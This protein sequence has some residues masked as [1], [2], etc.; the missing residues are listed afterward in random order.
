MLNDTALWT[1]FKTRIRRYV[2]RNRRN[3]VIRKIAQYCRTYLDYYDNHDYD[4]AVNGERSVLEALRGTPIRQIFDVGANTGDWALAAAGVF[5]EASIH[6]F[7]IVAS[8]CDSLKQ[9]VASHPQIIVNRFG[10]SDQ[11]GTVHVRTYE[12]RSDLA[13]VFQYT[14]QRQESVTACPVMRGDDYLA[15]RGLSKIDLMKIDVEGGERNV[16][17]GFNGA[18]AA[19]AISIIQFEYGQVNIVA[20]VL[21]RDLW[22]TLEKH[23]YAVGKIYPTYVDFRPYSLADEDFRGPNF[24]AVLADREDLI[25][26]VRTH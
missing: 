8:T 18:L 12:G 9:R 17:E 20:G 3:G 25:S 10:L 1:S 15:S 2:V 7:E 4:I 21:L 5:P 22:L 6:A 13:T 23:G 24:L 19:R 16:L 26:R 11:A 14:D